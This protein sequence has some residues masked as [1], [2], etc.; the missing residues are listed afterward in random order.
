MTFIDDYLCMLEE[1]A[2]SSLDIA[3]SIPGRPDARPLIQRAT[4]IMNTLFDYYS[5]VTNKTHYIYIASRVNNTT[6]T[7]NDIKSIFNNPRVFS[8]DLTP[9]FFNTITLILEYFERLIIVKEIP[10]DRAL[11]E[12]DIK[13]NSAFLEYMKNV[14][15]YEE[16]GGGAA[17]SAAAAAAAASTPAGKGG[18]FKIKPKVN[19]R[20]RN[21][22]PRRKSLKRK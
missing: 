11:N 6:Y 19:R 1:I 20:R 5:K 18:S 17:S 22:S 3:G 14:Y 15:P 2:G 9:G 8:N 7:L 10:K 4:S 13:V 16:P 21:G 12:L